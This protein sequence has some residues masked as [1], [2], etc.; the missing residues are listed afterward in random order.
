MIV[1]GLKFPKN[2]GPLCDYCAYKDDCD[3]YFEE[4][5]LIDFTKPI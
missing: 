1:K 4:E 3:P 5:N 2:V